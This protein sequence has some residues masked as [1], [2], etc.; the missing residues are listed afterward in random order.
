MA[1]QARLLD[2]RI[3]QRHGAGGYG[4]R[5]LRTDALCGNRRL[6]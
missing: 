4:Y 2:A 1:P 3:G 6:G 5:L